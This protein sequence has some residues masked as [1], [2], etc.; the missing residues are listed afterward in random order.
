MLIDLH[1][2]LLPA[3]DDG[4]RS[5]EESLEMARMCVQGGI[6]AMACTP[7]ILP[8]RYNN[9]AA[10]IE[11]AVS[12]LR[13][14]LLA[15]GIPLTLY[16]GADIHIA[17]DLLEKLNAGEVPTLNGSRYF[18]LEP[19]GAIRPIQFV[20]LTERLLA[21]GYVP[22][23]TH[24]ERLPWVEKHFSDITQAQ[25]AG[26]LVQITAASLTGHF[27]SLAKRL[28]DRFL[29]AGRIDIVAS[30]AH[31]ATR[32]PPGLAAARAVMAEQL[33]EAWAQDVFNRKPVAIV[34][35]APAREVTPRLPVSAPESR[36]AAGGLM[37][38]L[39]G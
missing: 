18:L 37:G 11:T 12:A 9:S 31:G 39:R 30:D 4:S 15:A 20:K 3:I 23:I 14:E 33:G 5:V 36:P 29:E 8:G 6:V 1:A 24:P 26:C 34:A 17:P 28:S 32:R 21:G 38:W 27:G 35:N 19:P 25:D 10:S 16:V 22:I 2:H 13:Q 7:H